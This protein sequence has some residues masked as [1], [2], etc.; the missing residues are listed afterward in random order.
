[1]SLRFRKYA[2]VASAAVALLGVV[3]PVTNGKFT[4][5]TEVK[6][7]EE[8]VLNTAKDTVVVVNEPKRA[9]V[10]PNELDVVMMP[11]YEE[12]EYEASEF[13]D[14]IVAYVD[15]FLPV[16]TGPDRDTETIGKLYPGSIADVVERGEVWSKIKSGNVE[17][18]IQNMFVCFDSEAEDL[19]ILL[20]GVEEL[21][22]AVS[23]EEEAKEKEEAEAKAAADREAKAAAEAKARAEKE[24]RERAE[25]EAKAKS[26]AESGSQEE[27]NTEVAGTEGQT[28]NTTE[29]PE[30]PAAEV[31]PYYMDL[32]EEDIY[33]L[34]CIVD[35]EANAEPYEGRLA[36]ANVVL[37][38]VRSGL[39]P[40]T[41]SGVIYQRGQF[42]GVLD[43][44]GNFS[45][46]WQARLASGPRNQGCIDAAREAAAGN[47]N[48]IGYLCFNGK[49][50]CN[51]ASYRSYIIIGNHCFYQR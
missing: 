15:D 25:A 31:S 12:A 35:W 40:N 29:Q 42:G 45:T 30:Q 19:A 9:M 44:S 11:E 48:V 36:V 27:S 18:Y 1:M 4:E 37:N 2:I 39:Y 51:T 46:R 14:K 43:A 28:E 7:A 16:R 41:V 5:S 49:N 22:E 34:S 6:V 33:L 38:R 3:L 10:V 21:K 50:Y 23:I 32:S 13:Q 17:G 8:V 47:N 20:G 26:E 24:A